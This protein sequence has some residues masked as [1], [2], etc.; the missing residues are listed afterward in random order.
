MS[1]SF[2]KQQFTI[3]QACLHSISAQIK[4]RDSREKQEEEEV[5]FLLKSKVNFEY[6][7][8]SLNFAKN[9]QTVISEQEHSVVEQNSS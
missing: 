4:E 2:G 3:Y 1:V 8:H 7:S 5:L 9:C 6:L